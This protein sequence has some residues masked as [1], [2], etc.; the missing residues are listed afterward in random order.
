MSNDADEQ[1]KSVEE[2][3]HGYTLVIERIPPYIPFLTASQVMF[4][5]LEC[6]FEPFSVVNTVNFDAFLFRYY[7]S[8]KLTVFFDKL[9]P[10]I[11]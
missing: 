10:G 8:G 5:H 2:W 4:L 11:S 9:S 3:R 6:L 7:L 1:A